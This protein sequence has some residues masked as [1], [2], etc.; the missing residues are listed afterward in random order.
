M[1]YGRDMRHRTHA[2]I[3]EIAELT[4][5]ECLRLLSSQEFGRLAVN[6]G[7]GP[8]LIRPVNY[9]FDQPTQSVMFRS[10]SGSKLHALL[11]SA[12]ATF[13]IDGVNRGSQTGWS[14]IIHG[15]ASEVTSPV[16]ISRLDRLGLKPWA[17]G[18]KPHWVQIRARTVSGRRIVLPDGAVPG[19]YL[20]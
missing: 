4:R 13:E 2:P 16:D 15:A 17:P 20:G 8:P 3:T 1:L 5:E 10:A 7:V 6:M 11:R 9:V 12:A 18:P 19:R 14:V